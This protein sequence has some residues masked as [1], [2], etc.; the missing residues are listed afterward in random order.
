MTNFGYATLSRSFYMMIDL[1]LFP[2]VCACLSSGWPH[3]NSSYGHDINL[4]L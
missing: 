3:R 2:D 4:G 1:L